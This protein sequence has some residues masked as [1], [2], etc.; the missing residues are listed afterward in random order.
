MLL[1]ILAAKVLS[2]GFGHDL[3]LEVG[4]VHIVQLLSSLGILAHEGL[5]GLGARDGGEHL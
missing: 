4:V 5:L 1:T 2:E 3:I